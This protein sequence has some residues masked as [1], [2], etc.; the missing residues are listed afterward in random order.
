MLTN[1]M[2]LRT[3]KENANKAVLD[4][5]PS[6]LFEGLH[7]D[8]DVQK[9]YLQGPAAEYIPVNIPDETAKKFSKCATA[10]AMQLIL[11]SNKTKGFFGPEIVSVEG[12]DIL[13]ARNIMNPIMVERNAKYYS[14]KL[15]DEVYDTQ[16]AVSEHVIECWEDGPVPPI[17][18]NSSIWAIV[19]STAAQ[20]Q[21]D[22][23]FLRNK[24]IRDTEFL[25]VSARIYAEHKNTH[26][27]RA[28]Q[29]QKTS[30]QA[31]LE[32]EREVLSQTAQRN[33]SRYSEA[34][35]ATKDFVVK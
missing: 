8:K 33:A 34:E 4:A 35:D 14:T 19:E 3:V 7:N 9:Y 25:E 32:E 2:V 15:N 6:I 16:Y 11:L 12:K 1:I 17:V 27:S 13:T 18:I 20:M 24:E 21:K 22:N 28:K 26:T 31:A 29:V 23:R 10:L 30:M 5:L